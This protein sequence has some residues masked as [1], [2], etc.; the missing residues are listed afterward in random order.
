MKKKLIIITTIPI[1]LGFFK[2]QIP[3]LKTYFDV[4]VI[5]SPGDMLK[6]IC[7]KV[8][9]K[10]HSIS[11][12]REISPLSDFISFLNLIFKFWKIKPDIIHGSTP[13]AGLLSM[14]GG[15]VARVP[16][17]IYYIHGL[18]YQGSQGLRRKLLISMEKLSCFFA[19]HIFSVSDGVKEV[20]IKDK[21]TTKTVNIIG[22]GS[23]NGIDGNYFT[24]SNPDI[25]DLS[26]KYEIKPIHF[27]FGFVGRIVADKGIHELVAAFNVIQKKYSF[28]RLLIVGNF[29]G[30]L[31]PINKETKWE[32][33]NNQNIIFAGFQKDIRPFLKMMSVFIFPSYR[34]GFGVSLMEAAAMK[35]PAISSD[36]IGCNEIIKNNYNGLLIRSKSKNQLI[37]AME[38]LIGNPVLLRKFKSVTREFILEKYEQK[39]L[40]AE[41]LKAYKQIALKE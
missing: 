3:T 14:I 16:I 19:T 26:N 29:E 5:S 34:E 12:K 6:E 1:S 35:V 10:G 40:Y 27:V 38:E 20:L 32:I 37:M 33:L 24:P 23:V 15:R 41:T 39:K 30:N 7:E 22:N 28:A 25:A 21:I 31:D 4:E 36:I 13:K 8:K 17:R 2:G 18:R 9:V 11:M